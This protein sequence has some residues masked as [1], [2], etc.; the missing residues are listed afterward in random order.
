[1]IGLGLF[2]IILSVLYVIVSFVLIMI[3]GID[4]PGYF[5]LITAIVMMGGIQLLSIGVIG[6]YVG[7]IY[8][9]VKKR[10]NYIIDKTNI[11]GE[12]K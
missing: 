8:Y 5:T 7:R 10:P 3:H 4:M 12:Q 9:E 1:M 6:E 11:K 2:L